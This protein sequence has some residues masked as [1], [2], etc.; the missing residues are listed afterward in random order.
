MKENCTFT[1]FDTVEFYPSILEDLLHRDILFALEVGVIL[2]SRKS[3]LFS[4]DKAWMKK[5]GRCVFD[6]TMGSYD[7]A[8]W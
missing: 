5:E 3:L 2:H 8:S 7:G 4:K 6:V 1:S